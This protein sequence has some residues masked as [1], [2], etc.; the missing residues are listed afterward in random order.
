L[1]IYPILFQKIGNNSPEAFYLLKTYASGIV[2]AAFPATMLP[3]N[4]TDQATRAEI[5]FKI[6][7]CGPCAAEA[8][9]VL[10]SLEGVIQLFFDPAVQRVAVLFDPRKVNILLI[11]SSLEPFCDKPRV[12]SVITRNERLP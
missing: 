9:R 8:D 6:F 2:L 4:P 12:V 3:N 10:R 11:L 7:P 5:A 1:R